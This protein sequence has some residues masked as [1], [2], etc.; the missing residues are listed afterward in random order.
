MNN[1][2][3][4][5]SKNSNQDEVNAN[6]FNYLTKLRDTI[7]K[8]YMNPVI[9]NKD[10][11]KLLGKYNQLKQIGNSLWRFNTL[12][13]HNLNANANA[14]KDYIADL[15]LKGGISKYKYIWHTDASDKTCA[16][17]LELDGRIFGF[18]EEV[19]QIPHPNCRC[20]VEII[21]E[22]NKNNKNKKDEEPCDC[23]EK[24]EE[25]LEE[26]NALEQEATSIIQ[27]CIN[28]QNEA[29]N[30]LAEVQ[31]VK[32]AIA[33]LQ[34]EAKLAT[35]NQCNNEIIAGMAAP[36]NKDAEL[37]DKVYS[38]VKNVE[39]AK[40]VYEV[41]LEN[42]HEME[43]TKSK[44]DKYYHAKANCESAELGAIQAIWAIMYS[45]GKELRDYYKK[46]FK[47]HQDAKKIFDDCMHDLLADLYGLLKSLEEG[48]CSHKVKGVYDIL[49]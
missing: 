13:E 37:E 26:A 8:N 36:I 35:C 7:I 6:V 42:K 43:A 30:W 27:D 5:I 39:S 14:E 1:S 25:I 28:S 49:K 41:F 31:D 10:K 22:N 11:N 17:C 21:E 12:K 34:S 24:I 46:V 48:S 4:E 32:N 19:P 16:K 40:E 3:D 23:W 45:I 47:E 44:I 9:S 18:N 15:V 33:E 20:S 29:E 38:L 2:K